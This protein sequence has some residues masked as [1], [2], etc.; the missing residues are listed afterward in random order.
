[1]M[2][3]DT[4]CLFAAGA[5]LAGCAAADTTTTTNDSAAVIDDEAVRYAND[6]AMFRARRDAYERTG[7]IPT[8]PASLS[9]D[10]HDPQY[11]FAGYM[12]IA[13]PDEERADTERIALSWPPPSSR[14]EIASYDQTLEQEVAAGPIGEF[15]NDAGERWAYRPARLAERLQRLRAARGDVNVRSAMGAV[16][17]PEVSSGIGQTVQAL[18]IIGTDNRELRS[19][20]SGHSMT[21]YPWRTFGALVPNNQSTSQ[22]P[23]VQCT[24]SKIGERYLFTNGHCVFTA[25]G[26]EGS[27]KTRD[28]WPGADG[29]DKTIGGGDSSPNGKKNIQWYY[30]SK[31]F[32]NN[33]WWSRDYA[34]LVLYDNTSSCNLGSLGYRV[35]NSLA[36]TATWNFGYPGVGEHC[37]NSPEATERCGGSLW[38]S[39]GHITRTEIPYIFHNHDT[40]GGQSGSPVYDFNGGNR[41]LLGAHHGTYSGVENRG[42]KIRDLVFDFIDTARDEKP[43]QVCDYD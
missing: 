30:Y 15:V 12:R 24:A 31:K 40:Q 6:M 4:I 18:G 21:S 42:I 32:V 26:G 36:G 25:G 13:T 16:G 10:P 38:G 3:R 5:A 29:L 2:R 27:L 33:G 1:M 41:Q 11:V 22:V 39:S 19:D 14:E 23:D 20:L 43:S 35:D 17:A 28:W 8:V 34:V 37:E 7:A 9:S